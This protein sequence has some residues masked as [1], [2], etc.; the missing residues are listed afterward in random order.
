MENKV[1]PFLLRLFLLYFLFQCVPL[2][3]K[4]YVGLAR[5]PLLK[6]RYQ[7]F[8]VLAH[9]SPS[10]FGRVQGFGDAGVVALLALVAAIVW[11]VVA[12]R[13]T[14]AGT[15]GTA[16]TGTLSDTAEEAQPASTARVSYWVRAIVRYRLAIALL[17][18]G[19]IKVFPLQSPLPSLGNLNTHYGDFTRWKLFSL[20]LGIVPSY[21]SFLGG[22]EIAAAL[23][24]L[25]RK[26]ASIGAL[27]VVFFTGNVLM[28]NI[29]YEGGETVYC[30]YLI[31]LAFFVLAFDAQRLFR[32]LVLQEPTEPNR[33]R[34]VLLKPWQR[35][36]RLGI[37][38]AVFVFFV[39]LLGIRTSWGYHHDPYQLP[40]TKGLSAAAGVYNVSL[41]RLGRDTLPYSPTDSVR[42]NNVVFEPWATVSIAAQR[43]AT[44][45]PANTENIAATSD[46]EKTYESAGT[47]GRRYYSYGLDTVARTLTLQNKNAA[48][49]TDKWVLRYTRPDSVHLVLSGLGPQRDSVYVV[50][51]RIDKKY[52]LE[53][54]T[55]IGRTKTLKL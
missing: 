6:F 9:Y 51:D 12:A 7:D 40:G 29:A 25:F 53:E 20:S 33:F 49:S 32:L 2:D 15:T 11:T 13:K 39:V 22:V 55:K 42:W 17:A 44:I 50:L 35:Y 5:L 18:Y 21:E 48:D 36:G 47:N 26:T 4:Y 10:F 37:K 43:P 24:L 28:S 14:V 16:A 19:F 3:P 45:D 41:F 46:L 38:A 30:A 54:A 23:L 34:V 31:S 8:F 1:K 52:L 27:I